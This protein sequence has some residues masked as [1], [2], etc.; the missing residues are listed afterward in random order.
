MFSKKQDTHYESGRWV[1]FVRGVV[2]TQDREKMQAHLD[3]CSECREV[4][5]L[6]SRVAQRAREDSMY[7]VPDYIVKNAR[8][9]Y[10]L[11][12]PEEVRLLPR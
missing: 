11:Q 12:R 10:S 2:S 5:G 8:A 9:L 1:D 4:A 6:F 7:E 3:G